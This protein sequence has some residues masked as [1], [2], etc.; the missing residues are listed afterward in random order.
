MKLIIEKTADKQLGNLRLS[1]NVYKKI[2][3]IAKKEKVSKQQVVRSI[4]EQIID[5]IEL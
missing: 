2:E 1:D 4:L 5:S 3:Q